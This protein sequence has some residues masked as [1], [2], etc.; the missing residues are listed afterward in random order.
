MGFP[1]RRRADLGSGGGEDAAV[2][3]DGEQRG[4]LVLV[5]GLAVADGAELQADEADELRRR[6][7]LAAAALLQAALHAVHDRHPPAH[8]EVG[9]VLRRQRLWFLGQEQKWIS[10]QLDESSLVLSSSLK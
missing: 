4:L 9:Q 7:L 1:G 2:G 10:H 8:D 3:D 6:L 5:D